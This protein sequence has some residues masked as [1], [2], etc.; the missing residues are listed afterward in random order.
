VDEFAQAARAQAER[1]DGV[2][3]QIDRLA[4]EHR[5]LVYRAEMASGFGRRFRF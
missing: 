5:M 1:L 4:A 3:R 2:L